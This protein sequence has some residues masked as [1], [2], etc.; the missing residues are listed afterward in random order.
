M[1]VLDRDRL[2]PL[3]DCALAGDLHQRHR[4]D[5]HGLFR[6]VVRRVFPEPGLN[7][8]DRLLGSL[9]GRLVLLVQVMGTL[10]VDAGVARGCRDLVVILLLPGPGAHP[11]EIVAG[12]DRAHDAETDLVACVVLQ[13][14]PLFEETGNGHGADRCSQT[15]A[16]GASV[17]RT[18][19]A[20]IR[21]PFCSYSVSAPASASCAASG[22]SC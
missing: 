14:G 18:L 13:Q 17:A 20:A 9:E 7:H 21:L 3:E 4:L 5:E 2:A 12:A 10:Y 19:A 15:G 1:V 6:V 11:D 22:R 16:D 8:P